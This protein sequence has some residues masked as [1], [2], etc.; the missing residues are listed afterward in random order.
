MF[1][2][3]AHVRR[4]YTDF[5]QSDRLKINTHLSHKIYSRHSRSFFAVIFDFFIKLRDF[6]VNKSVKK[7]PKN[8]L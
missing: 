4:V 7:S 8:R 2:S 5:T 1:P 6:K 3:N